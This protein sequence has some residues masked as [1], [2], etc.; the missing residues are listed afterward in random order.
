MLITKLY[1][2]PYSLKK[3]ANK[4]K[5]P[6]QAD[7]QKISGSDFFKQNADFNKYLV[8]FKGQVY[9]GLFGHETSSILGQDVVEEI[10]AKELSL[11][12]M[13]MARMY[14]A[15][16]IIKSDESERLQD[17]I[18]SGLEDLFCNHSDSRVRA[19]V[20]LALGGIGSKVSGGRQ[21]DIVD[22]FIAPEKGINDEDANVRVSSIEALSNIGSS[23]NV[24]IGQQEKIFNNLTAEEKGINDIDRDV[25]ISSVEALGNIGSSANVNAELQEKIFSS[26]TAE[27]KGVNDADN[28]VKPKAFFS[29]GKLGANANEALQSK[30]FNLLISEGNFINSENKFIKILSLQA[31][32]ALGGNP[33]AKFKNE[34]FAS[35][36]QGFTDPIEDIRLT[37]IDS[38]KN[39]VGHI[40]TDQ[41]NEL[42]T[43]LTAYNMGI[44]DP[45]SAVV[46]AN[47]YEA[48]GYLGANVSVERQ[49][50]IFNL[51]TTRAEGVNAVD[52]DIKEL[53]FIALG[54][55]AANTKDE[56]L[57]NNILNWLEAGINDDNHDVK[58]LS[59]IALGSLVLQP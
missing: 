35:L 7:K 51:L 20:S 11:N 40:S 59:F 43:D 12:P 47:A 31:L 15:A 16:D 28:K 4:G 52:E 38:M 5:V 27:G 13:N 34:I 29:L 22:L 56:N 33:Q 24:N 53:S 46:K 50:E 54:T 25:R 44:N 10:N 3:N 6:V 42:Y 39:I 58:M 17:A 19:G 26:L 32:A 14:V 48:L 23:A 21:N 55:L 57:Q 36:K 8:N 9:G 30:M 49:N 18:Y 1:N 45:S 37:A 41:K 2:N